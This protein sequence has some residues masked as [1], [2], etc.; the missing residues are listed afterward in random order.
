[1]IRSLYLS[2]A[3]FA[4]PEEQTTYARELDEIA[5][6]IRS[7]ASIEYDQDEL[8]RLLSEKHLVEST[9]RR[10]IISYL[11]KFFAPAIILLIVI[12]AIY[13]FILLLSKW[14]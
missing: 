9:N 10:H 6:A 3:R 4:R 13:A 12:W 1:M 2:T 14:S 11:V 5:S 7:G 8:R